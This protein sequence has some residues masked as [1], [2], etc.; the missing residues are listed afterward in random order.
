MQKPTSDGQ[1]TAVAEACPTAP[2]HQFWMSSSM[3]LFNALRHIAA[4][5]DCEQTVQTELCI[6]M[7]IKTQGQWHG[8]VAECIGCPPS[9]A[10]LTIAIAGQLWNS[11]AFHTG[12][13]TVVNAV[14]ARIQFPPHRP[15]DG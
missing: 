10:L 6:R 15:S 12:D 1:R 2:D 11:Y 13:L 4:D 7:R 9:E 8:S 5:L 3:P 14:C